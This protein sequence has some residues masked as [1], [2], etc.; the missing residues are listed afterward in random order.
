MNSVYPDHKISIYRLNTNPIT[1]NYLIITRHKI[2]VYHFANPLDTI[3][4]DPRFQ[5]TRIIGTQFTWFMRD[6]VYVI[7]QSGSIDLP[8]LLWSES[9]RMIHWTTGTS[10]VRAVN[11]KVDDDDKMTLNIRNSCL[12]KLKWSF[13]AAS[14]TVSQ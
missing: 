4:C 7:Y 11:W 5:F 13:S 1:I 8:L 14:R 6:T 10:H 12:Q 3:C 9:N 2:P